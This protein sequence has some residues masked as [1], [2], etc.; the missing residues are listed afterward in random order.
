M[1]TDFGGG[2]FFDLGRL[3]DPFAE[4]ELRRIHWNDPAFGL[5]SKELI[6]EPTKLLFDFFHTSMR[7][8]QEID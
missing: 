8:E 1:S 7:S 2:L 4:G 6:L 5:R 3:D